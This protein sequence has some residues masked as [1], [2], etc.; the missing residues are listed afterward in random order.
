M[1]G[2]T[3]ARRLVEGIC[4]EHGYIPQEILDRMSPADRAFVV[5]AMLNK[6]KLIASSVITYANRLQSIKL[7]KTILTNLPID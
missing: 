3:E 4:K 2:R 6:D 7:F 1:S 5:A